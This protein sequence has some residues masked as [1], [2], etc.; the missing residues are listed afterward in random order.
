MRQKGFPHIKAVK[1]VF[2]IIDGA[3]KLL[4]FKYMKNGGTKKYQFNQDFI[5]TVSVVGPTTS[6]F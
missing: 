4:K 3:R 1:L 2:N 5:S 6:I